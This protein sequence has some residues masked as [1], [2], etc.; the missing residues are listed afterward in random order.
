MSKDYNLPKL[1]PN[2]F[3]LYNYYFLL[4]LIIFQTRFF[5]AYL[6][7]SFKELKGGFN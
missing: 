6:H 4:K 2:R 1:G 5:R 3:D 7:A